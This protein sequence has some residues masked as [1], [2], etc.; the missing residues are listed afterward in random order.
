[1][2]AN[3]YLKLLN[4]LKIPF[5]TNEIADPLAAVVHAAPAA[6]V[7]FPSILR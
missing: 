6:V 2:S 4:K 7:K 1:V 5:F 3:S